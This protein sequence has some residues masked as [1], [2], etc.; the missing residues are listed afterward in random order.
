[1]RN[2]QSEESVRQS[3]E[4]MVEVTKN[5]F[6]GCQ[7]DYEF[8]VKGKH[9]WFIV[10][11]CKEPYH[12]KTLGY[13]SRGAPK[14]HPEYLFAVR[15]DRL[16]LNLVD[17]DDPAY[18]HGEVI[19][20]ALDFIYQGLN[21]G[22]KVLVHCNQGHS[23]S[24]GIGLLYMAAHDLIPNQTLEDAECSFTRIYSEYQ[25]GKG[26]R[27]FLKNNWAYYVNPE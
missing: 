6:I 7:D 20:T 5:L 8:N 27:R 3:R 19:K 22:K 25:P 14:D 17:A 15:G 13:K 2:P 26:I 23:R 24:A 4:K 12:R 21:S 11:A 18:I 9:G 10:H 1:M 16:I